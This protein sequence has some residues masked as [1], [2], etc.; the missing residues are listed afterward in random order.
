MVKKLLLVLI[1]LFSFITHSDADNDLSWLLNNNQKIEKFDEIF[2]PSIFKRD[3]ST[4]NIQL[5]Y[6]REYE[7]DKE[8]Q[9]SHYLDNTSYL[10]P[11]LSRVRFVGVHRF[12][13]RYA[14]K[15]VNTGIREDRQQYIDSQF[16]SYQAERQYDENIINYNSQSQIDSWKYKLPWHTPRLIPKPLT[17]GRTEPYYDGPVIVT[18]ALRFKINLN[19]LPALKR[20][21]ALDFSDEDEEEES[22]V[23]SQNPIYIIPGTPIRLLPPLEKNTFQMRMRFNVKLDNN[24]LGIRTAGVRINGKL[25]FKN[26]DWE[27]NI[28]L[29]AKHD[30]EDENSSVGLNIVI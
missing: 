27:M 1:F 8:A 26:V 5:T 25:K 3:V 6:L 20:Y 14:Q 10:L 9:N 12:W 29:A 21:L 13:V 23:A 24:I 17:I 28:S 16:K 15:Y 7:L 19:E 11:N 22:A 2:K 30:F 18:S 4:G